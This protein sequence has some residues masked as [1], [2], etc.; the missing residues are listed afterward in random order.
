MVGDFEDAEQGAESDAG[1]V[2]GVFIGQSRRG[3]AVAF[4]LCE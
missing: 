1:E 3:C 2:S 4:M